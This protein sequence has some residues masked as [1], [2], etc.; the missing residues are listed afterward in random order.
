MLNLTHA[1]QNLHLLENYLTRF[2]S[3]HL[4]KVCFVNIQSVLLYPLPFHLLFHLNA[5]EISSKYL[6]IYKISVEQEVKKLCSMYGN[7]LV[8]ISKFHFN[9]MVRK[10]EYARNS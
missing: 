4:E 10:L 3:S 5:S 8:D 6:G 9:G 1:M 2:Q 7:L